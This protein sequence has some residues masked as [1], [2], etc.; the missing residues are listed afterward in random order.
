MRKLPQIAIK[1]KKHIGECEL[2]TM[3]F[4]P[5]LSALLSDPDKN[6]LLRWSNV[7]CD[8]TGEMRPDATISKLCQRDFGPSLGFGEVKLARPSTDN[9]ALCHDLLRLAIFAKDTVD[10]NKLQ[11]AMTFQINGYNIVFFL[12]RLR[13][14]GIYFM[15]EIGQL[16]FPRSL[17]ELASFV[18]L[19]S[20]RTLLMVTETLWRLCRPLHDEECWEAK[21]RPTHPAIYSL[22]DSTKDRRRFCALRFE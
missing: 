13:H 12:T 10:I 7:T 17:E 15:Q 8:E 18:N 21:R 22:I 11:A 20:I 2:F 9:H 3:Y 14:D 16:T 6:V 4:D 1:T 19:K 5:I